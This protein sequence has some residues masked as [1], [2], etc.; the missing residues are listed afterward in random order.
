MTRAPSP[1]PLP[2]DPSRRIITTTKKMNG[3][4]ACHQACRYKS[5][6]PA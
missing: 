4:A 3:G 1:D 6:S 2:P 5:I